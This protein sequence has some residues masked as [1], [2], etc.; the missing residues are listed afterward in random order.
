MRATPRHLILS[1]RPG[2]HGARLQAALARR[3]AAAEFAR[4]EDCRLQ[5]A[6]PGPRL[7]V[8]GFGPAPPAGVF[9][10]EVPGGSLEEVV[11]YLDV[12]HGFEAMGVPVY[13]DAGAIERSVDKVRA[14]F[15][16]ALHGVPTPRTYAARDLKAA[17]AVLRD[18]LA[19]DGAVVAK[20]IFG[21]QGQGL[22]R[23]SRDAPHLDLDAGRGVWY[24]QQY[25]APEAG[26]SRDWRVLV[27]GGRA[28]AAMRRE[29]ADWIS[30]LGR[31][32]TGAAAALTPAFARLAERAVAA[33]G[34]AYAGV[35]LL[36][37]RDGRL[38]VTEVNS[39]PAWRGLQEATGADVSGRI[40][41]G[42]LAHCRRGALRPAA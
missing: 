27:I 38:W 34:L 26:P 19:R 28:A 14:S 25:V 24:L 9:V 2:W 6:A 37:G 22:Q 42:Y 18:W 13:N 30:N 5:L 33:V 16:F 20:P 23:L 11:Y 39:I 29:G 8:P 10:R 36:R 41:D 40:A 1:G 3:G 12:L 35:D 7:E 32:G 31:G 17:R 21:S 4:L 15:L